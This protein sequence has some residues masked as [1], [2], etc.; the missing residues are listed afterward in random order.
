MESYIE[1]RIFY[2]IPYDVSGKRKRWKLIEEQTR[3]ALW[4]K[5]AAKFGK[6]GKCAAGAKS[7]RTTDLAYPLLNIQLYLPIRYINLNTA[8]LDLQLRFYLI[9][10]IF[11]IIIFS[12]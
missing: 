9:S 2:I 6:V 5:C 4:S 11:Y 8:C 1:S 7:L 12:F 10:K 3:S